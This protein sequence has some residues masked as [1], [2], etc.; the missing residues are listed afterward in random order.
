[1]KD[2]EY[3]YGKYA[4]RLLKPQHTAEALIGKLVDDIKFENLE[5]RPVEKLVS[6]DF[7]GLKA[8]NKL[9]RKL[10]WERHGCDTISLYGDDGE[11]QCG[12]CMIDFKRLPAKEIEGTWIKQIILRLQTDEQLKAELKKLF[13]SDSQNSR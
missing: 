9:L 10:L 6:D 2:V 8:E 13:N 5:S 3:Y 7:G 4:K 11:L 1:M 12:K